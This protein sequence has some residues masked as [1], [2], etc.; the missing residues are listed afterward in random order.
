MSKLPAALRHSYLYMEDPEFAQ[1]LWNRGFRPTKPEDLKP[2]QTIVYWET[3]VFQMGP[4]GEPR[5]SAVL[6]VRAIAPGEFLVVH[7]AAETECEE[8]S[9]I[10]AKERDV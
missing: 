7:T 5:Y 9:Q 6:S 3:D 4:V 2:N 1:D 8:E 10:W